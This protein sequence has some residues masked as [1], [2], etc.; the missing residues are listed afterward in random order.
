MGLSCFERGKASCSPG[1]SYNG[2]I[3][4]RAQIMIFLLTMDGLP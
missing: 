1:D 2:S 3:G 4:S